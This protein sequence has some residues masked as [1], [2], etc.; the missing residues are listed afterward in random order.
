MNIV[1]QKRNVL[2][3]QDGFYILFSGEEIGVCGVPYFNT[4]NSTGTPCSFMHYA[5][6]PCRMGSDAGN[7]VKLAFIPGILQP[8]TK[9][10]VQ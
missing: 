4:Y 5:A 1:G 6:H 8:S 10:T 7:Q 2:G 3:Q 9:S